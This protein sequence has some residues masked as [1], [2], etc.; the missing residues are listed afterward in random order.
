MHRRWQAFPRRRLRRRS[1]QCCMPLTPLFLLVARLLCGA[2]GDWVSVASRLLL[3]RSS[4]RLRWCSFG[5]L[6][7]FRRWLLLEGVSAFGGC[8]GQGLDDL[9]DGYQAMASKYLELRRLK[10]VSLYLSLAPRAQRNDA[11]HQM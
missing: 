6:D 8:L 4:C 3:F 7:C 10:I 1:I 9:T 5:R 11:R 2:A